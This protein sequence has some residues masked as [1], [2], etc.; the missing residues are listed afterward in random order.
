MRHIISI[1][2]QLNQSWSCI[3]KEFSITT[4]LFNTRWIICCKSFESK[5]KIQF[6]GLFCGQMTSN[7][8]PTFG[9]KFL[10]FHCFGKLII[11]LAVLSVQCHSIDRT[12]KCSFILRDRKSNFFFDLCRCIIWALNLHSLCHYA[13]TMNPSGSDV[14]FAFAP[15]QTNP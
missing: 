15:T 3:C 6:Q 2:C 10:K 14:P 5:L 13:M 8:Y 4:H 12:V 9:S 7:F 11:K 1:M